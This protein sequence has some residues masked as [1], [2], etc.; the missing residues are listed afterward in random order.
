[1]WIAELDKD[2][3]KPG[4]P[5]RK[6]VN[7]YT[8]DYSMWDLPRFTS[9]LFDLESPSITNHG[10]LIYVKTNLNAPR[11]K[12]ITIDLL[13]GEP[14]IRDFIPELT[15]AKLAQVK[16][17][18]KEYFVAIYKRNVVSLA[19]FFILNSLLM[20]ILHPQVKDEI[21]LYS[22]AGV[23]LTRLAPDFVGVASI[24]NREKQPHFFLTVS[25]FNTPG[26]IAHYD[27]KTSDTQHLTIL[28]TTKL[29]GLNLDDFQSTQVWYESK[30]G[31][32]IPMF[33]VRHKSTKFDGTAA[34]I[35][36]GD[37]FSVF[38]TR[39]EPLTISLLRM[40]GYG[41]FAILANPFF[42]PVILTFMQTYNTILAVP[43]IRGGGEFGEDWH[44]GGRRANKVCLHRLIFSTQLTSLVGKYFRWFHRC[45][46]CPLCNSCDSVHSWTFSHSSQFLVKNKY[47]GPGKVVIAGISNG[48]KVTCFHLGTDLLT[49][50]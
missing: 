20:S 2:G 9:L 38:I 17:V 34:A 16:C 28:R 42:S 10:S 7:E 22:K 8:A 3:V 11:Y 37:P 21:Y 43:N 27:F 45:C 15:D 35:Q 1:M 26:T 50:D 18:N 41:G 4:I 48:G 29:N 6:V 14:E 40:V 46:V 12:A 49:M 33:I 47:A 30:D 39:R 36:Y 32:K 24:A 5:W 44:K 31:T 13:T 23:Q 19:N 25:G